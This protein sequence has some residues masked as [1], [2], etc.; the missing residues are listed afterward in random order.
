MEVTAKWLRER[1]V[2][3][4]TE[5]R[6][7]RVSGKNSWPVGH[8]ESE[9]DISTEVLQKQSKKVKKRQRRRDH[10]RNFGNEVSKTER[11]TRRIFGRKT[12]EPSIRRRSHESSSDSPLQRNR[13]AT[14]GQ[15][16]TKSVS[17]HG[18]ETGGVPLAGDTGKDQM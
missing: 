6:E 8:S 1:D 2:R 9:S 16:Q 5:K 13:S 15:V 18:E 10:S 4:V 3:S 11:S 17:D 7:K 14:S 12:Q